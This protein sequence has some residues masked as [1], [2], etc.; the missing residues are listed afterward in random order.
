[1]GNNSG[2]NMLC[3]NNN[4]ERPFATMRAYHNMYPAM[5]LQNLS[6]LSHSLVN[7]T[8]RPEHVFGRTSKKDL[9]NMIP[10]GIALTAH[11]T[12]R[13]AVNALCSVR[14]MKSGAITNLVRAANKADVKAKNALRKRKAA[15][16]FAENVR[17]KSMRA[18]K[19]DKA[20]YTAMNALV[21]DEET[22]EVELQSRHRNKKSRLTFL[23]EQYHARTTCANPRIYPGLGAEFRNKYGKL[24]VTPKDNSS[25]EAYLVKLIKAMIIEDQDLV[26]INDSTAS[27]K[28]VDYIRVI[29]SISATYTNP[30][31]IALKAEFSREI[32]NLAAPIDDPVYLDLVAKY[33]G[34]ILYDNETRASQKL[35]RIVAVQYIQSYTAGRASCWE[36]TCEPVKRDAATHKFLVPHDLMVEGS[37]LIQTSALMGYALAEY[38]NGSEGAPSYL[39]WVQNYIDHFRC[40]VEPKYACK[41]G[42]DLP[43]THP[44]G[45]PKDLP[46]SLDKDLPSSSKKDSPSYSQK[47]S[48]RQ[49]N[50][51]SSR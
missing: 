42:K 50:A 22:L 1:M 4:A 20:D 3:H 32:F 31:A 33:K 25:V 39:P 34:S 18:E 48:R 36:A 19:R 44:R 5:T 24:R 6:W 28:G 30:K 27:A 16:D 21:T 8:H 43:P 15:E 10:P 17:L 37:S 13:H 11:P 41:I 29:P 23:T 7:G 45:S 35:F 47:P 51:R 49:T 46:S 26:G 14:T 12:L 40:V 2:K 9:K 38:P